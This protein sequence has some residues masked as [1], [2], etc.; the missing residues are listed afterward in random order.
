MADVEGLK[1]G[2]RRLFDMGGKSQCDEAGRCARSYVYPR[3][4]FSRT[5]DDIIRGG[6]I[7]DDIMAG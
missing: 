6:D 5:L 2:A 4:H 1:A 3:L 7:I